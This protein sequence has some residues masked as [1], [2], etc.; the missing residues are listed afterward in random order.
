M[1]KPRILFVCGRNKWRSPT[2]ERIYRDDP[3]IQVRSAG[4]SVKSGHRISAADLSWA[5]LV[6]VMEQRYKS[7]ILG[8]FRDHPPIVSL[9]IPDEFE[10][11]DEELIKLIREGVEFYLRHELN[12]EQSGPT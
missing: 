2:A 3:R 10:Y 4:V 8:T 6:I 7:R 11:M 5:N 1:N 9:D 12:T